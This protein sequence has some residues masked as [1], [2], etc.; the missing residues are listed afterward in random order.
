MNDS[1][2]VYAKWGIYGQPTRLLVD[3]VRIVEGADGIAL[4]TPSPR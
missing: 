1:P 4:A 2:S 3:E